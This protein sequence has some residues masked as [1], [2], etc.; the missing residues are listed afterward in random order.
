[1]TNALKIFMEEARW[2]AGVMDSTRDLGRAPY[3]RAE[4]WGRSL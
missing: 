3:G 4:D 2:E 1:M